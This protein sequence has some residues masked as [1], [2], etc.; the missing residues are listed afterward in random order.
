MVIQILVL[1]PSRQNE[2]LHLVKDIDLQEV[3]VKN[4][5]I[6]NTKKKISILLSKVQNLQEKLVVDLENIGKKM[7]TIW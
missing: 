4:T 1:T 7:T 6:F 2:R 3:E 5:T